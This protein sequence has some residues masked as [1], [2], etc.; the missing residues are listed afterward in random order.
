M[1]ALIAF[2]NAG[3]QDELQGWVR[4]TPPAYRRRPNGNP[5]REYIAS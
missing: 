1:R 2:H 3:Y 4:A 5:E